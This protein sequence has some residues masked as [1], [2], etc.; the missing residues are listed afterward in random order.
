M[1]Y[2]TDRQEASEILPSRQSDDAFCRELG[3]ASL[4]QS[5]E[6]RDAFSVEHVGAVQPASAETTTDIEP[7]VVIETDAENI[8]LE[9]GSS[10]TVINKRAYE[11]LRILS[12]TDGRFIGRVECYERGFYADAKTASARSN[13]F[14]YSRNVVRSALKRLYGEQFRKV[15]EQNGSGAGSTYRI[16]LPG[17][18]HIAPI[19]YEPEKM[20]VKRNQLLCEAL[21]AVALADVS[22]SSTT[23]VKTTP[24]ITTAPQAESTVASHKIT[25]AQPLPYGVH[26][27]TPKPEAVPHVEREQKTR[28]ALP[29]E[30]LHMLYA[31]HPYV[32]SRRPYVQPI[33]SAENP[34]TRFMNQVQGFRVI[35]DR[36]E[37]YELRNT[38]QEG[39]DAQ[40]ILDQQEV[41]DSERLNYE[42]TAAKGVHAYLALYE[43]NLRLVVKIANTFRSSL[44]PVKFEELLQEGLEVLPRAIQKYDPQY[45]FKF[46]TYARRWLH[47]AMSRYSDSNLVTGRVPAKVGWQLRTIAKHQNNFMK[48]QGRVPSKE[49]IV[50]MGFTSEVV[51]WFFMQRSLMSLDKKLDE[52]TTT[53]G[54]NMISSGEDEIEDRIDMLAEQSILAEILNS[55]FV[56]NRDLEIIGLRYGIQFPD[57]PNV[58]ER[59]SEADVALDDS[60][61]DHLLTLDAIGKIMGLNRERI[62]QILEE[63]LSIT[64]FDQK[65]QTLAKRMNMSDE[66]ALALRS[67][68]LMKYPVKNQKAT[69]RAHTVPALEVLD[70]CFGE[71]ITNFLASRKLPDELSSSLKAWVAVPSGKV[72]YTNGVK[73][74]GALRYEAIAVVE[75][76]V[77]ELLLDKH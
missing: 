11:L 30:R 72:S 34:S 6:C 61:N 28:K 18:Q 13:A 42:L 60:K 68:L 47:Q 58:R 21:S 54:Y 4:G 14:S 32:K 66:E 8:T 73:S 65:L 43:G 57:C 53:D 35:T 22:Q 38:L 26:I 75:L 27:A 20:D 25:P 52:H 2:E 33:T 24:I 19:T 37:Q 44:D 59:I 3:V 5:V 36:Q 76:L 46:S 63:S 74:L 39:L 29:V 64:R 67:H 69:V 51:D 9:R 50:A 55:P 45:G 17:E 40:D 23:S 10:H 1:M 16:S 56:S 7:L 48:E 31:D 70:V 15:L 71:N 49:E 12:S 77:D 62:R 41:P